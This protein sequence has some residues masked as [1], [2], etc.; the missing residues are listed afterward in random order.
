MRIFD[1]SAVSAIDTKLSQA[2]YNF[3]FYIPI[4]RLLYPLESAFRIV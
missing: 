1:Y 2:V 3:C 4:L